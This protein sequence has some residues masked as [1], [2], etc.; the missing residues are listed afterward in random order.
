MARIKKRAL[1]G[2]PYITR[3]AKSLGV[4]NSLRGL[5]QVPLMLSFDIGIMRSTGLVTK[6]NGQYVISGHPLVRPPYPMAAPV[7]PAPMVPGP[8]VATSAHTTTSVPPPA[9]QP[10]FPSSSAPAAD[11]DDL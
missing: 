7:A 6:Q 2:G 3:L 5:T 9:P 8:V 11:L 10:S 4:F 1:C